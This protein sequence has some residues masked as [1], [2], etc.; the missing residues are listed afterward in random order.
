M[1]K[2][3]AVSSTQSVATTNSTNAVNSVSSVSFNNQIAVNTNNATAS[4]N[5]TVR[6]GATNTASSASVLSKRYEIPKQ[7]NEEIFDR[8]NEVVYNESNPIPLDVELPEGLIF[9]VQVGAFRN[10]IP[11]DL[12]KGFAPVTGETTPSGLTRYTA[13]F[14]KAFETADLAKDVIKGYG[15]EDAFVVAFFNGKRISINEARQIMKKQ[16]V[17][18]PMVAQQKNVQSDTQNNVQT[19]SQQIPTS[20]I[21]NQNIAVNNQVTQDNVSTEEPPLINEPGTAAYRMVEQMQGLLYTVQCGVYSRPVPPSQLFNIQPLLVEKTTNGMLRYTSGVYNDV[22]TAVQAKNRIVEY[23]IKDAFVTAYY[24][25]KRISVAEAKAIEASNG[26]AAFVNSSDMNKMPYQGSNV[27]VTENRN[28]TTTNTTISQPANANQVT[29]NN[30]TSHK[31]HIQYDVPLLF[32]TVP[33]F[34]SNS[35][36]SSMSL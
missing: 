35:I 26:K 2:A 20:V 12:F 21:N 18:T 31:K 14:F 8:T 1:Q 34:F 3:A 28:I 25:G 5:Q 10:R 27:V 9:K 36:S 7:L 6:P 19:T 15:Y 22:N 4:S 23:G 32:T 33:F 17:E 24:N 11:Q 29:S 16:G 13:G 30:N